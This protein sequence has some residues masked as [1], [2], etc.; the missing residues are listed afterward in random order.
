MSHETKKV[1]QNLK[2]KTYFLFQKCQEFD[3]F[4][5]EHLKESKLVFLR[6]PFV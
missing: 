1:V 5:S 4:S 2:K 3:K 6:D